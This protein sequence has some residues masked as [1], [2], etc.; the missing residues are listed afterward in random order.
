MGK[1]TPDIFVDVHKGIRKA[2]FEACLLLGRAGEDARSQALARARLAQAIRFV[3]HHGENEDA[4][5][6]PL[7]EARAAE[8][9]HR[10]RAGHAQVER[11][12]AGLDA[13]LPV[14]VLYARLCSFTAL[15][16]EH[17]REEEEQLEPLIRAAL[18][19]EELAVFGQRARER[20]SA[21]DAVM[22]LGDMLPALPDAEARAW[23]ERLPD[24]LAGRLRE[25]LTAD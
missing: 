7:I 16:L 24:A 6:L 2:L 25:K 3:R 9:W 15:Y 8:A 10:M 13:A 23:L 17:M 11:E 1:P 4:I 22:M 21:D 5:L 12:L 19:A 14:Q 20:T 18:S